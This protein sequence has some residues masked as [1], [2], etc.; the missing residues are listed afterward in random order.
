LKLRAQDACNLVDA[1]WRIEP[2]SKLVVSVKSNPGQHTSAECGNRGY[3]NIKPR[4]STPV[5]VLHSGDTHD[6]RAEINADEMKVFADNQ[7]V[8][9]GSL[10][11]E[12]VSFDGPLGIRSDNARLQIQLRVGPPLEAKRGQAPGCK[13]GLEQ[14]E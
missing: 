2:K 12:V 1:L 3:R 6:L 7:I 8:W 10:G 13:F 11:P 5:P 9:E 14:S 4:R